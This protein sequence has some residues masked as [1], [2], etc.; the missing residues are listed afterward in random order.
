MDS[1]ED[2]QEE[3]RLFYVAVTRARKSLSLSYAMTGM[4]EQA[5]GVMPSMFIQELS[6]GLL[7]RE[8]RAVIASPRFSRYDA[9]SQGDFVAWEPVIALEE[10]DLPPRERRSSGYLGTY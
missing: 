8:E 10:S 3:R 6:S 7:E 5:Y 9:V 2:I 1:D 4:G